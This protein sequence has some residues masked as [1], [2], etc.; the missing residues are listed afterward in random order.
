MFNLSYEDQKND[1]NCIYQNFTF[2]NLASYALFGHA[3][4]INYLLGFTIV[5]IS[6]HQVRNA[7]FDD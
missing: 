1:H 6:M 5:L 7:K 2:T 4:T 3:L